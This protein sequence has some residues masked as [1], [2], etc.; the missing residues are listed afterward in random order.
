MTREAFVLTHMLGRFLDD[1]GNVIRYL[2][3]DG[4]TVSI[5]AHR[6]FR[7]HYTKDMALRATLPAFESLGLSFHPAKTS[8]DIR[9][10]E[11]TG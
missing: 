5:K 3:R 8:A 11:P 6:H 2:D 10:P 4:F 9:V 1:F 7:A